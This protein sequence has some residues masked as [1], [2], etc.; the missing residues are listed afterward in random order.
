MEEIVTATRAV[1]DFSDLLNTIKFKGHTFII[2]RGGKPVARMVPMDFPR[3]TASL[4]DLSRLLQ[5]L[6]KLGTEAAA[7]KKDLH[8]ITQEQPPLPPVL[9]WE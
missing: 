6:P 7:L 1:R 8:R 5:E 9:P 4:K 3:K 2:E